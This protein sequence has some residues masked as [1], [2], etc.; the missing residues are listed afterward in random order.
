MFKWAHRLRVNP[1]NKKQ[2]QNK[3]ARAAKESVRNRR[4][5]TP[6]GTRRKFYNTHA[7]RAHTV[8]DYTYRVDSRAL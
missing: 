3:N 8:I 4:G 5:E 6:R 1:Q 2:Q 7:L